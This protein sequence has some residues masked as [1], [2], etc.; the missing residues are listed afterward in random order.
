MALPVSQANNV[1]RKAESK[2]DG[3]MKWGNLERE[4]K[5]SRKEYI[6]SRERMVKMWSNS[7]VMQNQCKAQWYD[8]SL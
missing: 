8:I 1:S 3:R 4:E 2:G 7:Y 5:E 6:G